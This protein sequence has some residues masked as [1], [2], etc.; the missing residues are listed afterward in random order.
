MIEGSYTGFDVAV[1]DQ[2][3]AVIT[4][5]Q[6][7]RLN[8]MTFGMRRDLCEILGLAQ[9]DDGVRVVVIAGTGRGFCAGMFLA[10]DGREEEP[11]LVPG[12]PPAQ[13]EPVNLQ[14]QLR[15]FSQELTRSIRRLDKIT[16]AAVNGFAIQ[17]GLSMALACDYVLAARSARLGSATLRMGYQPD[18]GGHWL[19]VEHLGV[20]R[21][22]DFVMRSRIVDAEEAYRLGL[23]SEVVDDDALV[24]R[25]AELASEL[26]AGP[27]VAMRLLKQAIYNAAHLQFDQAGNDIALRTA[28]S[29]FHADAREGAP[30]WLRH[31]TPEFNR[32]LEDTSE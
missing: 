10:G 19:L 11:T 28:I 17:I 14:A 32:W 26:A 29:D 23:V 4:L 27:Q 2:G 16:I 24:E 13:H 21:A 15:L 18:E 30:A 25:A 22:L 6:P 31:E 5:N 1:D 7:E 12:R 20:K 9:L 8:A 3:V